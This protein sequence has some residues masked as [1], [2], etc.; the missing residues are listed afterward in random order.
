M[1]KN[2]NVSST[3]SE[4]RCAW[5]G[6]WAAF[7]P[8][9][10]S[11]GTEALQIMK[12]RLS[13]LLV[14]LFGAFATS[15]VFAQQIVY[16]WTGNGD[17]F[18]LAN[19][20]NWSPN[21][22]P[23]GN[24]NGAGDTAQ[25]NGLTTSNLVV[26]YG[27]VTLPATGF[28]TFGITLSMT[29]NQHQ[30]VQIISAGGTS[31]AVGV[32]NA[33]DESPDAPLI[34][35]DSTGNLLKIV[36][37]P[38]GAVH[39]WVNNSAATCQINGSV[40]WQAGGGTAYEFD[41]AG[42]GDWLVNSFL[43]NDNGSGPTTVQLEGPG[44]LI[45]GNTNAYA[46]FN[47]PLGPVN[48]NA[49][50]IILRNS[51]LI[52]ASPGNNI[53][54]LNNNGGTSTLEYDAAGQSD[55]QT[56]VI[57]GPGQVQ[58]NNGTLLLAGLN[59]YAGNTL[60]TGGELVLDVAEN[61]GNTNGPVGEGGQI[62]FV[63]GT[64]GFSVN[65][66][67][68]YSGRFSPSAG[69]SY[70]FDTGG[71]NVTF[72]NAAGLNSVGGTLVKLGNGTLTLAA[73]SGYSG[74]TTVSAGRL[75]FQGAKSGTG[76][77]A[78]NDGGVLGIVANGSQ[79]T[80]G[81][82][83]IG[84]A[85]GA[86]IEFNNV[87]STS[88]APVAA[89]T[90]ASAGPVTVNVNTGTFTPGQ[91]YPLLT[92]TGGSVPTFN[93]G[94]LNGYIGNLTVTG[95][96]TL[97]LNVTATA[98]LWTGSGSGSWDLSAPN[99]W[100]Q[101]GAPAVFTNGAPALLDDSAP[102]TTTITVNAAIQPTAV[103]VNNS[104]KAYSI[105]SSGG[106]NIGGPASLTKSGSG[107]L[108]LSGG[109]NTYGGVTT[110]SGGTLSV[111]G[112]ANGSSAS[113]IG[114]SAN[115]AGSLVFN[116]GVLQYTGG[117]A[118]ID[119]LFTVT[120]SGGTIDGSGGTL[121]LNNVGALAYSGNGPRSLTL[122]GSAVGNTLASVYG[123]N[124]GASTLTMLGTGKWILTG[125]NT[126]SG[127]TTINSGVL[128]VGNG[129]TG[130]T[131]TG[132][133]VNNSALDF[134]RTGTVTVGTV[135][136]SGSV[137]NDG[138]GTV[139]MPGNNNYGGVTAIN[140][141]T[142][143][144]G[145]GG[146]TGSIDQNAA[147]FDNGTLFFNYSSGAAPI[148]LNGIISGTGQV[149]KSGNGQLQLLANETFTGGITVNAGGLLQIFSGNQGSIQ[150]GYTITNNG[151]L[152]F[153]RQDNLVAF[154]TNNIIGSG[155]VMRDCNNFNVGDVTLLGTN[156]YTGGTIIAGGILYLG[157][158][159][160]PGA[161]SIT[162]NVI[163]TNSTVTDTTR[164]LEFNRPSGD[165]FTFSGAIQGKVTLG[166]GGAVAANAGNVVQ[167]GN[168]VVTLTGN[169]TYPA[170]TIINSG[171]IQAGNGGASG[172]VGTGPVTD[173]GMLVF[174]RS[175]LGLDVPGVISGSGSLV[176][177]GSGE[178]TLDASNTITGS[179]TVS[180]GTLVVKSALG[181]DLDILAGATVNAGPVG[182]PA[183][184]FVG[185]SLNVTSGTLVVPVNTS[186]GIQASFVTITG[187]PTVTGSTLKLLNYGP[188]LTVGQKLTIFNQAVTGFTTIVTP[189]FT[190]NNNL[191]T[192]GSVTVAT[193]VGT[194]PTITTSFAGGNVNLTWPAAYTGLHLQTQSGTVT[195]GLTR[196]W[197]TVPGSDASNTFQTPISKSTGVTFYRLAP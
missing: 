55:T 72:T 5:R 82:L 46:G 23:S 7:W 10:A 85:A 66:V 109:A 17:G 128:Q 25:W 56:R 184:V 117:G 147:I 83:T 43:R 50:T 77:I 179:T 193:V 153:V 60:L 110:I 106:N 181:G 48:I 137:T 4:Q 177:F 65:N 195:N 37:R 105:A 26:K 185:G 169:N 135:T 22:L 95:G 162:G 190:V 129:A 161:G 112:L 47:S 150:G 134:N 93:L 115:I 139:I 61:I 126:Y 24:D 71:Q 62:D 30:F 91:S 136:G 74:L 35:G 142:V 144:I 33:D 133:I 148:K 119:R 19:A 138:T 123:D 53:I 73:G 64:L 121:T 146:G 98:F 170:G 32:T 81:T 3:P 89:G 102:G 36:G 1:S 186:A 187:V 165:D 34:L 114:Q 41:F 191:G 68:D 104:T 13:V 124:G 42:S 182:A 31:A 59:T 113:D 2:P 76:A 38:A 151:T 189:G 20:T 80:P 149:I 130:A 45:W 39:G 155:V 84:S 196:N 122:T 86:T 152:V 143:Q 163:F 101:N 99:N 118:S 51:G 90:I 157:D 108:T 194:A 8:A 88:V 18:G 94:I 14:L 54:A 168:D 100:I 166:V 156:T 180:N 9:F 140:A 192:D 69:Q 40:E 173:N 172:S 12:T 21:G 28:G 75:V 183:N 178:T 120:T 131:G 57:S 58:V 167:N 63:G 175:D 97:V 79:V 141:G 160:T 188:T 96:N 44:K 159:S 176:Q 15:T 49:S 125:N 67:Y 92:W 154:V 158:G 174:N 197:V 107:T 78:V 111:S 70:S 127:V 11:T 164:T 29:A 145:N 132:G 52:P 16:Q 27:A 87:S 6:V 103:T 171:V 116:G